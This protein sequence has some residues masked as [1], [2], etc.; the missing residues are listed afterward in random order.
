MILRS[1]HNTICDPNSSRDPRL[2]TTALL[3]VCLHYKLILNSER[4]GECIDFTMVFKKKKKKI[5][6]SVNF[7]TAISRSNYQLRGWVFPVENFIRVDDVLECWYSMESTY[8]NSQNRRKP[9]KM[10]RS[11]RFIG[12]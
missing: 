8:L 9:V 4:S 6:V 1:T 10:Y 12:A 5:V 2:R 3:A 11:R 7:S